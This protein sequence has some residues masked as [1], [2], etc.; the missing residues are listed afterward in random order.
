M[1][2]ES[3]YIT[4]L[5]IT[6]GTL[7]DEAYIE[8]SSWA[9]MIVR[10]YHNGELEVEWTIGPF[11]SD[12]IGRET[13]IRYTVDG[14]DVQYRDTGE[15]FTDSSGRRLIKRLRNR[16]DDWSL[17]I[18]YDEV[19]NITGNYYPIV[20]RI[21][22]KNILLEWLNEKI[23]F[24][25]AIYTDRSH[26]GTSL[27][28]GQLELMLHRQTV[29][30]DNL[31]V[32]EPLMEVGLDNKGLIVRGTHK[33]RFDELYLVEYEDRMIAQTMRR[34]IL[35]MFIP[36]NKHN[37]S[38]HFNG[39][40]GITK[41]LPNNIHLLSLISWPLNIVDKSECK[42]QLLVRFENLHTLDYSEYTQIDVKHLF[43]GITIIDVTEMIITADRLK[44]D[45]IIHRLHWP[46][47]PISQ[48]V[49]KN[50]EM[51]SSSISLKL[52]PDKIMTYLLSYEINDSI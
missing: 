50:Y 21:M 7:V 2:S 12:M 8:Y 25:L 49:I 31:G 47:E 32:N 24:G 18:Q 51:N 5:T 20:N 42:K 15:F 29:Y 4:Y 52:P 40:S 39:W 37:L 14:N 35:P 44:E 3:D 38:N 30:D 26:G 36:V 17:P 28:D 48:C 6:R 41:S 11:P 33:I 9:S 43:Y 19:Q 27:K 1:Q 22:I 34:P 46:T 23:P 10:L 45:A 13:I 16:R